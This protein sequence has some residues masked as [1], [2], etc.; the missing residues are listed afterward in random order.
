MKNIKV[1]PFA[2][3]MFGLF[4]VCF[5]AVALGTGAEVRDVW[6]ALSIAYKTVPIMLI[7]W[8]VF[9]LYAWKWRIFKNWLVPIP[10]LYGTWQGYIQST[11][12]YPETG[13]IPGPIPVLLTIRQTFGRISCV[14][15][16]VEM[17]SRSYCVDFWIDNDEQIRKLAYCYTSVPSVLLPD[18][19]YPHDG[20]MLFEIIGEPAQKLRGSYW[21]TRKTT[22]E[23]TMTFRCH[24][25]FDDLPDDFGSHPI[26]GK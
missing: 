12:N 19:S 2:F 23:V 15:R 6:S 4:A 1:R 5:I 24:E 3:F 10:C 18:S 16:T 26:E 8:M 25:R 14:M 9:V 13:K 22:G 21:T 7:V 20:A 17:T 11:W